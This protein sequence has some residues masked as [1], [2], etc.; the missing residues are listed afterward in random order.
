M[1]CPNATSPINISLNA[2]NTCD[3][4]CEY[5]FTY[6]TTNLVGSNK[7]EYMSLR[8]DDQ[9]TPPVT[10][11]A[12]KYQVSEMRIYHPS[13]HTFGGVKAAA[14]IVLIHTNVTGNGSLLVCIPIKTGTTIDSLVITF[15][16]LEYLYN[17]KMI[18]DMLFNKY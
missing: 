14:E 8:P 6:Q 15:I 7:G 18:K 17:I 1:S 4:K 9:T 3:L 2:S 5:S 10:Y 16:I 11:N 12:D 13:L